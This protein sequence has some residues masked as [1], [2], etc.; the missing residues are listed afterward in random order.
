MD[1]IK[2][3]LDCAIS[4]ESITIAL[5][6]LVI[7]TLYLIAYKQKKRIDGLE[8]FIYKNFGNNTSTELKELI[9]KLCEFGEIPLRILNNCFNIYEKR[10]FIID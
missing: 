6:S 4:N 1:I 3:L 5:F 10:S 8:N 9:N 7:I 2:I